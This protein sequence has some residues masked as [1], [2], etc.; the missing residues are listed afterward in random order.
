MDNKN[1]DTLPSVEMPPASPEQQGVEMPIQQQDSYKEQEAAKKT[2][3][4]P[5]Q[6]T[7]QSFQSAQSQALPSGSSGADQAVANAQGD[8][9][10]Q[11]AAVPHIAEES[12]LIEKEW[13]HKAKQIVEQT[14]RDPHLQTKQMSVVKADYLK[15][16]YN[17]D[18]KLSE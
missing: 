10:A 16:R 3:L 4:D 7:D 8:D 15:K 13:I 5:V 2:E 12:E 18:V 6:A 1:P 9:A 17:R 11:H 14:R